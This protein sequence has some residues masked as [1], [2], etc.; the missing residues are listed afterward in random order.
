MIIEAI[1]NAL[2]GVIFTLFSW[3]NFPSL[4]EINSDAAENINAAFTFINEMM[5]NARTLI[6][7]FLPWDIVRFGLPIIIVIMNME[8]I[9]HFIMWV[10]RKIPML[11]VK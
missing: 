9:Y 8:H 3:L 6:N 2:K 1:L 11:N 4:A 10:V 7:L 5:F